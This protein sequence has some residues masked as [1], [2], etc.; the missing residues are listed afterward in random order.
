MSMIQSQ[1]LRSAMS[2]INSQD[3]RSAM[4]VAFRSQDLWLTISV[5]F[6]PPDARNT[7]SAR[8]VSDTGPPDTCFSGQ[9]S[10]K[11]FGHDVYSGV[12]LIDVIIIVIAKYASS[13]VYAPNIYSHA[14]ISRPDTSDQVS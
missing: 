1:D 14:R 4:R 10:K 8:D 3:L 12:Q 11:C 9:T 6:Q 7:L 5:I 13:G 2:V